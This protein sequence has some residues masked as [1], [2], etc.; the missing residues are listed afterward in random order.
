MK[1]FN[2]Y[3]KK[4]SK[5]EWISNPVRYVVP[6]ENGKRIPEITERYRHQKC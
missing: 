6:I 3:F 4:P 2:A 1:D 5:K